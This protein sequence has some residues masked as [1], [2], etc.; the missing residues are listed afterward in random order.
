[1]R[2]AL[3]LAARAGAQ[4]R[5][6]P[7]VGAVVV[8]RGRIVGRDFHRRAGQPHAEVLAL[9]QAGAAAR[10]AT[11]YVTLEPCA[12]TGRTPPCVESIL[13]AGIR[14]V[15]AAMEDPNPKNRGKGLKQLRRAGVQARTG[16]LEREARRLNPAFITWMTRKRPFVTVKAAQSLDGKI[17]TVRGESRWIS[18]GQARRWTHRLRAQVDAILIGVETVLKDDPRLTV[19]GAKAV[20]PPVRIVLDAFLRTPP[21]ARLFSS[22]EPVWI[23]ASISALR[24]REQKLRRRGAEVI[25]FPARRGRVDLRSVLRY[26][27]ARDI[28]HLLIEGGG[29]TLASAFAAKAVDR[30]AF[31]IAPK[32]IGGKEAPTAVGGAG[33][34]FLKDAVLLENL[35]MH[36][37]GKDLL[38]TAD[39][40]FKKK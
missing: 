23:A 39:V 21:G 25:R 38:V 24:S 18:G 14:R 33:I 4:T 15:V 27:A 32:I 10:G 13:K 11:L 8:R 40:R 20:R 5:P 2:L 28:A 37:L 3:K 1:M 35:E 7:N 16:V 19:R 30:A 36:P 29:E 31:L 9:R 6:N 12:H 17:A 22:A 26:L 34:P